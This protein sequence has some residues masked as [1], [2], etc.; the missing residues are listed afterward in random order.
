MDVFFDTCWKL[1]EPKKLKENERFNRFCYDDLKVV[2]QCT[3]SHEFLTE[4]TKFLVF[5]GVDDD[6]EV[7][8]MLT[9]SILR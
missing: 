5:F 1:K 4:W 8:E 6:P 2:I 3:D 7:L 9:D